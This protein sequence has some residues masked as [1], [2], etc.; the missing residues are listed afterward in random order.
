MVRVVHTPSVRL[1]WLFPSDIS[2]WLA[3]MFRD[4]YGVDPP[5]RFL[6]VVLRRGYTSVLEFF[7]TL[8]YVECSRV[9]T[10]EIVRHRIA[11]YWQSSQ[12]YTKQEP[13]ILVPRTVRH[14][15]DAVVP[16]VETYLREVEVAKPLGEDVK[17]LVRYILPNAMLQRIYIGMNLRELID[18]FIPLR[19]CR[20]A[21][22]EV[23]YIAW[24]MR[25]HLLSAVPGEDREVLCRVLGPRCVRFFSGQ[26]CPE[27]QI[28]NRDAVHRCVRR[29]VEEMLEQHGREDER[30]E[31]YL[32]DLFQV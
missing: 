26:Y 17:Q 6:E 12:R 24:N 4:V 31:D 29:A 13:T 2:G 22:P 1:V 16:A 28:A 8:W 11:S 19:A 25:K 30:I 21:Q 5:L 32:I 15:V 18:V 10:H 7:Y 23:R 9:A 3:K 14:L 20:R 27:R